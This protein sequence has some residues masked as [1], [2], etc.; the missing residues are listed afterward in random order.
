[1]DL[2]YPY[3]VYPKFSMVKQASQICR[4]PLVCFGKS[5]YILCCANHAD[6]TDWG[7]VLD[8]LLKQKEIHYERGKSDVGDS[9]D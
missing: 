3:F 2:P 6:P 9:S 5:K 4:A 7:V 1:M 8:Y